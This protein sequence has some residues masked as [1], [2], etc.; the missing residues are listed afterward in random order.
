MKK[1][2]IEYQLDGKDWF[3]LDLFLVKAK[4]SITNLLIDRRQTKT[5]LILSSVMEKVDLEGG[6]VIAKE[7][8]FHSK[9][10]VNVE[11]TNSNE[12]FSKIKETVFE[13]LA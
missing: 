7:A 6:E 3:Y 1:F 2:A 13:S 8:A 12:W 5:K 10:E 11:S 4:Q 9:T